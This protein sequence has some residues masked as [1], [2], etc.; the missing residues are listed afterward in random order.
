MEK[1]EREKKYK[2]FERDLKIMYM[3]SVFNCINE[4]L[5][6]EKSASAFMN[7]RSSI[8]PGELSLAIK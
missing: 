1:R 2:N 4:F 6:E 7:G 5:I 3:K 8:G